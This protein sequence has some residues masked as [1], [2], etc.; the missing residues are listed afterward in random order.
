MYKTVEYIKDFFARPKMSYKTHFNGMQ[1]D[2]EKI[3]ALCGDIQFIVASNKHAYLYLLLKNMQNVA[4][5]RNIFAKHGV[6]VR[7]HFSHYYYGNRPV[8]R[9]RKE[10]VLDNSFVRF[11]GAYGNA[12]IFQTLNKN[13]KVK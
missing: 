2:A 1:D 13:Q 8:M 5:V 10:K 3:N 9:V 11:L 6:R 12:N 4:D 7:L